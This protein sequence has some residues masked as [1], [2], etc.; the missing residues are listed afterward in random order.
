MQLEYSL[1]NLEQSATGLVTAK[2]WAVCNIRDMP[3][4]VIAVNN[5]STNVYDSKA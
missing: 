5:L 4:H 2:G 1:Q 3:M